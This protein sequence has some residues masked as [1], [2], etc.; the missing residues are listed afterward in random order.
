MGLGRDFNANPFNITINPGD[1]DVRANISVIC[2]STVERSETFDIRLTLTDNISGV[3]LHRKMSE[4]L[5][6]D[7]TGKII[8][9]H[10]QYS[11]DT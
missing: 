11:R 3:E 6:T 2:D 5:I 4:G 7:S 10:L 1:N 9:D 8:N